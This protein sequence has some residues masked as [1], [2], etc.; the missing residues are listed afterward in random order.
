MLSWLELFSN[1][2]LII[3]TCGAIAHPK[4]SVHSF[5]FCCMLLWLVHYSDVIMS[6]MASRITGVSI[7]HS[8]FVQVDQRKPQS[9]AS[10]A[11]E[12]NPP[13]W[14]VYSPYKGPVTQKM[15]HLMT[16]SCL[17]MSPRVPS[18]TLGQCT[19]PSECRQ[20]ARNHNVDYFVYAPSQWETELQFKVVSHWRIT[21]TEWSL[22][23]NW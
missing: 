15:F 23:K 11:F 2:Y 20:T 21:C 19:I 12:G 3:P 1:K 10:L 9:S 4:D 16:S 22:Y 14:P 8:T 7:V 6:S 18:L 13:R 17:P 5:A